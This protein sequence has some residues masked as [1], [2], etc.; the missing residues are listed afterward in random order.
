MVT[1]VFLGIVESAV[2]V[3][4]ITMVAKLVRSEMQGIAEALRLVL[5]Y[6]ADA[7]SGFTVSIIYNN[8][9]VG[10]VIVITLNLCSAIALSFEIDYFT[11]SDR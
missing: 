6:L 3:V 4:S 11:R 1:G 9:I 5:F 2:H 10:R 7:L 8:I